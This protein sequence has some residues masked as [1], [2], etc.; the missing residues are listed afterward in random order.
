MCEWPE[1]KASASAA[2]TCTNERRL[3][4][5]SVQIRWD[6]SLKIESA[7]TPSQLGYFYLVDSE[8]MFWKFADERPEFSSRRPNSL[9]CEAEG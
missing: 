3:C 4:A 6:G 8:K 1:N 2:C 5:K 9:S 7:D